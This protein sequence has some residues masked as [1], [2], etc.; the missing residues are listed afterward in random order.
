MPTVSFIGP[1]G[2]KR[3]VDVANGQSAMKGAMAN[4]IKGIVAE[5]GGS[6]MC[7]TCHVY[8]DPAFLVRLPPMSADENAML[9]TT[10]SPREPNSRLS[11]QIILNDDL[12]G[13]IL[14]LPE[15]QT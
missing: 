14:K 7:G 1:D 10:S 3:D 9:D 5:C 13:L 4:G 8:V 15:T 12:A 2:T 11:C 6:A